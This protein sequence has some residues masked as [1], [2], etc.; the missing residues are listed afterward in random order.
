MITEYVDFLLWRR[1]VTLAASCWGRGRGPHSR[2]VK[3]ICCVDKFQ[4]IAEQNV[5]GSARN[6]CL[7]FYMTVRVVG[8]E[9]LPSQGRVE[10][11]DRGVWKAVCDSGWDVRTAA[12]VV[13]R[14]LGFGKALT[15]SRKASTRLLCL[16]GVRCM[17]NE[18]SIIECEWYNT[19]DR[20]GSVA[21][22]ECSKGKIVDL[23]LYHHVFAFYRSGNFYKNFF[24]V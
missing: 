14:E 8:E 1:H 12:S 9:N 10:V 16:Y 22:V 21:S 15:T 4:H 23:S 13:C 18:D 24:C 6:A 17:G 19:Y 5:I 3:P 11:F 2:G 20:F 7:C